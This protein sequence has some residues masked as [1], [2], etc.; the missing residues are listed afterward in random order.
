MNILICSKLFY[1]N[2]DIGAV[3]VTNFA[4][5]LHEMGHAIT[6]LTSVSNRFGDSDIEQSLR[7]VRVNNSKRALKLMSG[8]E[9]SVSTRLPVSPNKVQKI[10]KRDRFGKTISSL[11]SLRLQLY[12][13]LLQYDWHR[14]AKRIINDK[15]QKTHFDIVISSYGP[16]SSYLTAR[17]IVEQKKAT[18]WI[19][20]LRDQMETDDYP[21]IINRIY[22]YY[23]NDMMKKASA[24]T[25]V[26]IGQREMLRKLVGEKSFLNQQ[27]HV[28]YNGFEKELSYIPEQNNE[29]SRKFKIV[30]TGALYNGRRDM[31][32]LF[33][34][35]AE[36]SSEQK[37]LVSNVEVHY[38]GKNSLH[39][40]E[41][42]ERYQMQEIIIDHGYLSRVNSMKLQQ[43]ADILVVLSWNTEKEQG[44]LSGKFYEYVQAFK[45]IISIVN[46]NVPHA[47][48]SEM[49]KELQ[50][51]IDCEHISEKTDLPRLKRFLHSEYEKV[52]CG[53]GGDF[54]PDLAKI[55]QFYYKNIVRKL[56]KICLNLITGQTHL[57]GRIMAKNEI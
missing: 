45:P 35:L 1:P 31:S 54:H 21:Q 10:I 56:E 32:M 23:E 29:R 47:E 55:S 24:I 19:S 43:S 51:G 17:Y 7:I 20:D 15:L 22:K 39:L 53:V 41:Q 49:V 40:Y 28:V 37:I 27:V 44:I 38:A 36:L 57:T 8:V 34:A 11:R 5:Y 14:Q 48:L 50:V 4:K 42:A 52:I 33:K 30:Y 6:V 9:R 46:G 16:L 12:T 25:V 13:L 18:H 3:R 2:N 26:S